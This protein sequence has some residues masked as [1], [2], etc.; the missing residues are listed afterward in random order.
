MMKE[1]KKCIAIIH[2]RF[3]WSFTDIDNIRKKLNKYDSGIQISG[4]HRKPN[5]ILNTSLES[6]NEEKWQIEQTKVP[7]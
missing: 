5:E 6:I 1:K 4:S 3:H 7:Q 2:H